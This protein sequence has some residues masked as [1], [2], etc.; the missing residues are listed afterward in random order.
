MHR[1]LILVTWCV[2]FS[3][4]VT[5]TSQLYQ[6]YVE[7][8]GLLGGHIY[9]GLPLPWIVETSNRHAIVLSQ[10]VIDNYQALNFAFDFVFWTM[11]L[12]IS[13]SSYLYLRKHTKTQR[14][15]TVST[16]QV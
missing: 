4:L 9:K 14:L 6:Y 13:S 1:Y 8:E 10:R 15:N 11:L 5:Y 7:D 16:K 3:L 12:L 2:A